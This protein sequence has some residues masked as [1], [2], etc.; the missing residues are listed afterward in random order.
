MGKHI[1]ADERAEGT[2]VL[3]VDL[4]EHDAEP[5][6][7][8]PVGYHVEHGTQLGALVEPTS[9]KPIHGVEGLRKQVA[10]ASELPVLL[11]VGKAEQH[12][13]HPRISYHVW[14]IEVRRQRAGCCHRSEPVGWVAEQQQAASLLCQAGTTAKT[15][16]CGEHTRERPKNPRKPC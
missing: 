10:E 16:V 7:R 13:D 4:G 15:I 6:G 5:G 14:H 2:Q 8:Y 11:R 1:E 9:S 12:R 3:R